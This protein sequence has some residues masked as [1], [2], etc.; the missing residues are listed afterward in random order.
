MKF[1]TILVYTLLL[2][3]LV[4]G[5]FPNKD[6]PEYITIGAILPL[7]GADSDEGVR[8]LN[9]LQIA[10]QEINEKGG[11]LGKKLD[12]IVLN[13]R[14]DKEYVLQ[15]YSVLKEKG[16]AAII[17]SGNPDIAMILAKVSAADDIPIFSPSAVNPLTEGQNGELADFEKSYFGN[18]SQIPLSDSAA[19]YRCVYTIAETIRNAEK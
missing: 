16:V 4:F 5:C 8:A 11:I 17:S 18:F 15:Q 2:T 10:K 6:K 14:G 12:I 3:L 9:G 7:T 13:D 1:S 19:A